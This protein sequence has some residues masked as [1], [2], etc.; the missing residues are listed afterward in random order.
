M[1][2]QPEFCGARPW[3]ARTRKVLKGMKKAGTGVVAKAS[4]GGSTYEIS[5][6]CHVDCRKSKILCAVVGVLCPGLQ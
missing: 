6:A 5:P 1:C 4:G 3:Y 2:R